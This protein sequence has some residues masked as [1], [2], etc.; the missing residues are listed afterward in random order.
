MDDLS[1]SV[2]K[3]L[4]ETLSQTVKVQVLDDAVTDTLAEVEV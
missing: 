2:A 3:L 4:A 1:E